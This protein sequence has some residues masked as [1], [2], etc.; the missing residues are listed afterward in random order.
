M[1]LHV[2]EKG[3]CIVCCRFL[4]MNK[5]LSIIMF[6]NIFLQFFKQEQDVV[7]ILFLRCVLKPE[8]AQGTRDETKQHFWWMCTLWWYIEVQIQ[9][10][11]M[12]VG[13]NLAVGQM[14]V[15]VQEGCFDTW[16]FHGPL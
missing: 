3:A 6:V 14:N 10:F 12:G 13:Y 7:T 8:L 2:Q 16:F 15:E 5:L 11:V 9:W 1:I 4:V